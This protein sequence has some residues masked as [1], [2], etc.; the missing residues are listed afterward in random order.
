MLVPAFKLCTYVGAS[1]AEMERR[2]FTPEDKAI[3]KARWNR[4]RI[5]EDARME[6][7]TI[8]RYRDHGARRG[9]THARQATF[10]IERA[11]KTGCD[12]VTDPY[13]MKPY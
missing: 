8:K 3:L 10:Q 4:T 9:R 7:E 12:R 5:G 1:K 2:T 13:L 11:I 6:E